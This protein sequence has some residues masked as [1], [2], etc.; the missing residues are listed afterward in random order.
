[1]AESDFEKLKR[2]LLGV[3][4]A[5]TNTKNI[6][7]RA[8]KQ[9]VNDLKT[10]IQTR[11]RLKLDNE[12]DKQE[13]NLITSNKELPK[14]QNTANEFKIFL[15]EKLQDNNINNDFKMP[16]TVLPQKATE[17]TT[18]QSTQLPINKTIGLT[19]NNR[20]IRT[21]DTALSQEDIEELKK[22]YNID[23]NIEIDKL[24]VKNNEEIRKVIPQKAKILTEEELNE[25]KQ[26]NGKDNRNVTQKVIMAPIDLIKDLPTIADTAKH[27][28]PV[29]WANTVKGLSETEKNAEKKIIDGA[30]DFTGKL[31]TGDW[32]GKSI[33]QLQKELEGVTGLGTTGEEVVKENLGLINKFIEEPYELEDLKKEN[34]EEI[35]KNQN[36]AKSELGKYINQLTPSL[37]QNGIQIGLSFIDPTLATTQFT[38]SAIGGY[39]DD[40]KLRELNDE[41]AYTYA[42]TMGAFEGLTE[43]I[44]S[45]DMVKAIK[46][47]LGKEVTN[48][49]GETALKKFVKSGTENFLQEAVMEPLDQMTTN[50]VTGENLFDDVFTEDMLKQSF[51]SG[52]AG[53]VSS[54]ILGGTSLGITS[55][56]NSL[57]KIQEGKKVTI[58]EFAKN[59]NDAKKAGLPVKEIG[60]QIVEKSVQQIYANKQE[61]LENKSQITVNNE[62]EIKQTLV[63]DDEKIK[64]TML[65]KLNSKNV[66]KNSENQRII[67]G[68][69]QNVV[70]NVEQQSKK[71]AE[72]ITNYKNKEL[73]TTFLKSAIENGLNIDTTE[74]N[75]LSKILD[76]GNFKGSFDANRFNK[77]NAAALFTKNGEVIFNP[78]T[79][80]KR[81]LYDLAIHEVGHAVVNSE[82]QNKVMNII[83]QND[84]YDALFD[85][86]AE[87]YKGEYQELS[88][89][90]RNKA[91]E[92]EMVMDWLGEN[93]STQE[94][95]NKLANAVKTN[96][97]SKIRQS[98]DNFVE[99]VKRFFTERFGKDTDLTKV[100][101]MFYDAFVGENRNVGNE[102]LSIAG[103]KAIS[104]IRNHA[105]LFEKAKSNYLRA[106]EMVQ[107]NV[108]NEQMIKETGWYVDKNGDMKFEFSDKDM[109]LKDKK[110]KVGINYKL[111]DILEH[112]TLFFFYP[113]LK[114]YNVEFEARKDKSWNASHDK[115]YK[116]IILNINKA[117]EKVSIE[118]TLLHEIQHAIQNLERIRGWD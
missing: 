88:P 21:I 13:E 46:T 3:K 34:E 78:N 1:M 17:Q 93:L 50:A 7:K 23:T 26:F 24:P 70:S 37:V 25:I 80:T 16:Q 103:T 73:A 99:A 98:I 19:E 5:V 100:K 102:K 15:A 42:L 41:Q 101:N 76:A 91:I 9:I 111:K 87:R 108:S 38:A 12:N 30:V 47:K 49:I 4:N 118:G 79:D 68:T 11:S 65:D 110:Y 83:K 61:K 29:T 81:G 66:N 63:Q 52:V 82:I 89:S 67:Q 56:A 51:K 48:E 107:N 31:M 92:E 57:I 39:Y 71:I 27:S 72:K 62:G 32:N 8:T 74:L 59:Y 90:Q 109:N 64:N 22:K 18:N 117:N 35:A 106:C 104:N 75:T 112:D 77:N 10:D 113:E 20:K 95:M 54:V 114:D 43:Q 2:I 14:N 85:A 60:K 97:Q 115:K 116:K 84:N 44:I 58:E 94:Y 36:K 33:S 40:A 105:E 28:L 96:N 69:T 6:T 86:V 53:L 45:Q 55:C